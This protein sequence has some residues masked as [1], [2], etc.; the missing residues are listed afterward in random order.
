MTALVRE[1]LADLASVLP[2]AA[3]KAVSV[4]E[5]AVQA[6]YWLWPSV[7]FAALVLLLLYVF[8]R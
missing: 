1:W 7:V 6:P 5:T 8:Q 3:M 2:A 4:P